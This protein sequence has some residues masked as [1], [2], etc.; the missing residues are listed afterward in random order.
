MKED[1]FDI[2]GDAEGRIPLSARR[3]VARPGVRG[4]R[5]YPSASRVALNGGTRRLF[6]GRERGGKAR[7]S[8]GFSD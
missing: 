3:S 5:S 6:Y 1:R 2:T 4:G 8:C 7:E